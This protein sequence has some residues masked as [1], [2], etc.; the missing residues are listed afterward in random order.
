M[1]VRWLPAALANVEA[2]IDYIALDNPAAADRVLARIEQAVERLAEHP[3]IVRPGRVPGTRELVIPDTP[4]IIPYRV[5][6][7]VVE[8]LRASTLHGVVN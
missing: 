4:Y 7:N 1:R 2:A 5:R 6:D 3:S 8:I